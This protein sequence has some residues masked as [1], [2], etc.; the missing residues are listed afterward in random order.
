MAPAPTLPPSVAAS[1]PHRPSCV[2]V[3]ASGGNDSAAA[4]LWAREQW[5]DVPFILWHAYLPEDWPE[6]PDYLDILAIY[7]RAQRVTVQAVYELTGAKTPAG[8]NAT[9]LRRLHDVERF[10]PATDNDPAAITSLRDFWFKA[11]NGMPPT[12]SMR[13][14]TRAFKTAPCDAWA[15]LHRDLLGDA[16]VLITGERRNESDVR[17]NLDYIETRIPLKPGNAHPDGW[18][19]RW[20]RP[21]LDWKLH[22]VTARVLRAGAPIHR[23]YF[24]QG[25]TLASLLDPHRDEAGRARLSCRICIFGN[26][27]H[28]LTAVERNPEAMEAH[29]T[30][31]M[32]NEIQSGRSWKQSGFLADLLERAREQRNRA[33][34]APIQYHMPLESDNTLLFE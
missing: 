2:V 16:A 6:T 31:L 20:L 33:I 28:I 19:L 18:R 10:G 1:L 27:T 4:G 21:L 14:C 8:F 5:P 34:A 9:R 17:K 3:S 7:L 24:D 32:Q 26:P 30:Q 15:R 29:T 25:E 12:K 22:E 13:W 11:R 23:G